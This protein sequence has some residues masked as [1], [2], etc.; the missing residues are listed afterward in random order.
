MDA[1]P[2]VDG[3]IIRKYFMFIILPAVIGVIGLFFFFL[4]TITEPDVGESYISTAFFNFSLCIILCYP[5]YA[6]P[7]Y[8]YTYKYLKSIL[9]SNIQKR[10]LYLA[11][12]IFRIFTSLVFVS[13]IIYGLIQAIRN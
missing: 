11:F 9:A 2:Y 6:L 13:L 8:I 5:L 10:K 4:G 12:Y 3:I 7:C 1:I